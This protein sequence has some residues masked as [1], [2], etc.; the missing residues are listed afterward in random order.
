MMGIQA[1]RSHATGKKHL[2]ITHKVLCFFKKSRTV[3]KEKNSKAESVTEK[4]R[5]KCTQTSQ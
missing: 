2:E 3:E 5:T 4:C 1:L